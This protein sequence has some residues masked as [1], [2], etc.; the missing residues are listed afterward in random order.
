MH[1]GNRSS[2]NGDDTIRPISRA[3][4]D[5]ARKLV[6]TLRDY[7]IER[8]I[9]SPYDRCIQSVLPLAH[10][11]G[12]GVEP[13]SALAEG[14]KSRAVHALMWEVIDQDVVLCSHGDIIPVILELLE[15]E[16]IDLGSKI[17]WEKAS[18]WV[19][20]TRKRKRRF[21]SARYLPPPKV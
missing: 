11:R 10:E 5:E 16:G 6:K 7:P 14:A 3:G 1:A 4:R 20:Q 9:S 12:V 2:W 18:T 17:R 21:K 19:V 8:I 15:G 13:H